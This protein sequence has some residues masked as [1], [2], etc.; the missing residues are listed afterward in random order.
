MIKIDFCKIDKVIS[1]EIESHKYN[2]CFLNYIEFDDTTRKFIED[3]ILEYQDGIATK[4]LDL[5]NNTNKNDEFLKNILKKFP[6]KNNKLYY[7]INSCIGNSNNYSII[8]NDFFK[9]KVCKDINIEQY[10]Q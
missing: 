10:Y 1:A 7:D 9:L 8:A 2:D 4:E 6:D 5:F 3:I